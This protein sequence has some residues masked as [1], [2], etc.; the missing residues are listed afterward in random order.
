[1][2]KVPLCLESTFKEAQL[3]QCQT[4]PDW[5]IP[6]GGNNQEAVF[7]GYLFQK[8]DA[9]RGKKLF[10][11]LRVEEFVP[12]IGLDTSLESNQDINW[13]LLAIPSITTFLP[14][15]NLH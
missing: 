6:C 3:P 12:G 2:I 14:A 10:C 9:R 13:T 7:L 5:I 4:K 8:W 11:T 1:M 15:D